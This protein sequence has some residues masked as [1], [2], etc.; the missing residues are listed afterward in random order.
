MVVIFFGGFVLN[1]Y[2]FGIGV[3]VVEVVCIVVYEIVI[4]FFDEV[5]DD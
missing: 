4:L 5:V 3:Y 2:V 1:V